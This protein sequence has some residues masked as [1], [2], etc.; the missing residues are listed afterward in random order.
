M[1]CSF[2]SQF[3]VAPY[4]QPPPY[5]RTT[6]CQAMFDARPTFSTS[7]T[8]YTSNRAINEKLPSSYSNVVVYA[9][10]REDI[11]PRKNSQSL[12]AFVAFCCGG[13]DSDKVMIS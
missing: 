12:R 6:C 13:T 10:A 2:H 7:G 5:N 3:F 9:N 8:C 4:M 1:Y 11:T